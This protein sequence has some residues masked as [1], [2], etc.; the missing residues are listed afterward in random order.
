LGIRQ[1]SRSISNSRWSATGGTLKPKVLFR[2]GGF[3]DQTDRELASAAKYLDV[4][5]DLDAIEPGDLVLGRFSLLPFY[6][7]IE[8]ELERR[9]AKLLLSHDDYDYISDMRRWYAD[10][11]DLTPETCFDIEELNFDGPYFVKGITNS[12]KHR[13]WKNVYAENRAELEVILEDMKHDPLLSEQ[14]YAIRKFVPLHEYTTLA[15]GTPIAEEYRCFVLDGELMAAGF[16]WSDHLAKFN[17]QPNIDNIPKEFLD[18][19]LKRIELPFYVV[20]IAITAEG[21]PIIVEL[22]DPGMSG[23][24]G[25]SADELYRN[26]ATKLGK[27]S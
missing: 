5:E 16:Y 19:V 17:E 14:P 8:A 26:I 10:L 20:D 23:L 11:A 13:G 22:N 7:D 12:L 1:Q 21:K 25:V 4:S 2:V 27:S 6:G 9:G 3:E 24:A 18:T 15:D